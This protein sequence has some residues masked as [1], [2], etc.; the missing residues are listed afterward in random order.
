MNLNLGRADGEFKE[1]A[2]WMALESQRGC[3]VKVTPAFAGAKKK[4]ISYF[5]GKVKEEEE[6]GPSTLP[7][8]KWEPGSE[9]I[10]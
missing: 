2:I 10:K 6:E 8:I 7:N 5:V 1:D 3:C 4:I 9:Y